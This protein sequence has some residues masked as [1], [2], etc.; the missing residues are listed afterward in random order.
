M[1]TPIKFTEKE[2]EV[3]KHRLEVPDALYEALF[4]D[5]YDSFYKYV[6]YQ[7][8]CKACDFLLSTNGNVP[9]LKENIPYLILKDCIEGSTFFPSMSWADTLGKKGDEKKIRK[10]WASVANSIENKTGLNLPQ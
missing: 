6:S 5:R 9:G 8:T 10:Q 7:D 3:I 4:M 1:E 2:W